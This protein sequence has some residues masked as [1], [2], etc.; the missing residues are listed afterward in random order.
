MRTRSREWAALAG[1]LLVGICGWDAPRAGAQA[2]AAPVIERVEPTSG[3][4]GTVVHVIGRRLGPQVQ[5]LLGSQPLAVLG[6]LPN[7]ISVRIPEGSASGHITLRSAAGTVRG[8]EFRVTELPPSPQIE[9]M[10]PAKGPPGMAVVLRG[11]HFSPRLTGNAVTLAGR[12]VIVSAATP[13]ELRLIV[14]EVEQGGPFVVRVEQ[15]GEAQSSAFEV[16]AATRIDAI[17]PLR[18]GPG[19]EITIRGRGFSKRPGDNRV[20]LNNARLTVK[21][22]SETELLVELPVRIAS[23]KLLVDVQ[24]AGRAHSAEALV[25]QRP[26][27]ITDFTPKSGEP[28]T[29][30]TVRGTNLGTRA[31]AV[32]A[33]LGEVRL[34]VRDARDTRL[35]LVIPE[36]AQTE[37]LSIRAHGV[38]P[39]WSDA[40]FHVLGPLEIASFAP[41]TGPAG[42]EVVIEG[43]GFAEVPGRNRVTIG[44][45]VAT[46]LE[47]APNRLK[48]R[49]PSAPS[50]AIQVQVPGGRQVRTTS[51]FVITVP[52]KVTSVSPWRG[53]VGSEVRLEGEGFGKNPAVLKVSLEGHPLAVQS[54][55]DDFA[56]VRITAGAKSGRLKVAVPLQGAHELDRDFEVLS[57]APLALP[58]GPNGP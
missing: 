34:E 51:P 44:G 19:A 11:R 29:R 1:A 16:T 39:A 53:P 48:V 28:G 17:E 15:A 43:R 56:V 41:Q 5:V 10:E 3:P 54:V 42:T 2:P 14:P 35:E 55:G 27:A 22:A 13:I 6:S 57:P 58:L 49:V 20:Y 45:H 8:Q 12:P 24:G 38:G 23:G 4:P 31:D 26:P 32:E 18:A 21:R 40:P 46:V 47:S 37:K 36:G 25:A 9:A 7:R 52:P 33:T 30:V 50:G